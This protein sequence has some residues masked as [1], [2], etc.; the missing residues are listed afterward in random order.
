MIEWLIGN[1]SFV[2]CI[3]RTLNLYNIKGIDI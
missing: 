1:Y 2:Y 3:Q